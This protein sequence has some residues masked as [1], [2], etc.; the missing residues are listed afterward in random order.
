MRV[1]PLL[2]RLCGRGANVPP[3]T[4]VVA[5]HPDDETI[6]AGGLLGSIAEVCWLVHVTDGAPS[7]KRFFPPSASGLSRSAYARLRHEE[8]VR[9]LALVG[10][11]PSRLSNLGVR[12]QEATFAMVSIADALGELLAKLDPEIVL[13]HA[14]EGGHPDHDATAYGVHAA[15]ERRRREGRST[16]LIVEMTGYH[17]EGG[18]TVRGEFL[19]ST[20]RPEAA[21]QMT[22]EDIRRKKA[23]FAAFASQREVLSQFTCQRELFRVAPAYDFG[24][25][26]HD[27]RLHYERFDFGLAAATWRA[28]ARAATKKLAAQGGSR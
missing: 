20:E 13:T 28:C 11:D 4:L 8:L 12:D 10:I 15:T 17:D 24:L 19:C 6:G 3:L 16:P 7:N 22:D 21:F 23:M 2:G 9:A 18:T 25:P 27:G 1:D 26:P 5:A 14:Y